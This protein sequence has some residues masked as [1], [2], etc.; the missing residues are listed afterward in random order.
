MKPTNVII[1]IIIIN[2]NSNSIVTR[3]K[4]VSV[5]ALLARYRFVPAD[6]ILYL[7]LVPL[8]LYMIVNLSVCISVFCRYDE[9]IVLV[10]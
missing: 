5:E 8:A 7:S 6:H 10:L 2:N 3:H 1:T 9:F 4:Y